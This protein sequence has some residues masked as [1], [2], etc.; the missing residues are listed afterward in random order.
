M[1]QL[2]LF[3]AYCENVADIRNFD[4]NYGRTWMFFPDGEGNPQVISLAEPNDPNV[5]YSLAHDDPDSKITL[6]LYNK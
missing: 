4:P 6:W 2:R 1:A 5:R 3:L